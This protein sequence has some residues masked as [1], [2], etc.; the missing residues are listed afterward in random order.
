MSSLKRFAFN[1]AVTA[2]LLIAACQ[3]R[4]QSPAAAWKTFS[5]PGGRFSI[6]LPSDPV[7]QDQKNSSGYEAVNYR[8]VTALSSVAAMAVG[9]SDQP[10]TGAF[11]SDPKA[12]LDKVRDQSIG[13]LNGKLVSEASIKQGQFSGRDLRISIPG[14]YTVRQQIFLANKRLYSL[15]VT[16]GSKGLESEEAKS[17]F[18][19]FKI[20]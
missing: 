12:V 7:K 19:S 14:G 11:E 9:Y 10:Q 17:F 13:D 20:L 2:L 18:A 5:P 6:L 4:P 15:M 16:A 3:D 8:I 1:G